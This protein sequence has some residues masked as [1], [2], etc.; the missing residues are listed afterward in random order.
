MDTQIV[1]EF[2]KNLLRLEQLIVSQLREDAC[3]HG[4]SVAQCHCLLAVE[5]LGRPSQ[6][7]L[8]EQLCLDKSSLSRTVE[9]LVQI[10]LLQREPDVKDRRV[11][12][13][14]M[15][16]QGEK[17]CST[18]NTSNDALYG[19]VLDRLPMPVETVTCAFTAIVRSMTE[20]RDESGSSLIEVCGK[21]RGNGPMP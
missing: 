16:T 15:T 14:S 8:A 4:V 1:R 19:R 3:C 10:G 17:T 7:E 5:Q 21:E 20:V 11:Y 2:S 12:R 6:N 13:I 18:I 9:G